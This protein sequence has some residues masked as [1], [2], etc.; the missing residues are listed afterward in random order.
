MNEDI[1][2]QMAARW[3]SAVV[4][5]AEIKNFTGGG[6]SPKTVANADSNGTG[7]SR[8]FF[9]GRRVCYLVKDLM[10]W[11]RQNDKEKRHD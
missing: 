3:P 8:R 4:A 7:P 5:R 1:F 2:A 6:I 11:L 10:D 9:I